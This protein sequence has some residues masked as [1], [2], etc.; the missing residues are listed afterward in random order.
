MPGGLLQL[1]AYGAQNQYLNGNPQMTFFKV[2]YRRYTNFSSEYIRQN[3]KGPNQLSQNVPIQLTCKIDRNGDLIQQIYFVFNIPD[4]YSAYDWDSAQSLISDNRNPNDSLYKFYW[5]RNL[6]T[7]I[8]NWVTISIGGQE[9]DK[10][11]GEWMNVWAELNIQESE[12]NGYNEMIGAVPEIFAPDV[13]PGSNG[14]YPVSSLNPNLDVDYQDP[15]FFG[16]K[17]SIRSNPYLRPPSINGRRILV[18]M[19]FWFCNNPGLSLPLIALQYHDVFLR[20]E[21]RPINELYTILET[22]PTSPLLGKRIRP[23]QL[24]R[25]QQIG[26]FITT[27]QDW[28]LK[29][30]LNSQSNNFEN[31]EANATWNLDPHFLINYYFLDKTE[32]ER[33]ASVSHEY[34]ITQMNT[35]AFLGVIGT[36]SL[37]LNLHH[38]SKQLI[39][40]TKRSD[41]INTNSWNNYT[42]WLT[43][44]NPLTNAFISLSAGANFDPAIIPNKS[45]KQ[46]F[47]KEILEKARILF[48]GE[49]RFATQDFNYFNNLQP[50]EYNIRSPKDG[51]YVFSFSI[52]KE[53]F[54]PSGACNMAKINK[55]QLEI[56]CVEVPTRISENETLQ[57]KY[58]FD[59]NMYSVNYNV[60]RIM[61]GMAGLVFTN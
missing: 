44:L 7:T 40:T 14:F 24:K 34:L 33:F 46:Y 3:V 58:G 31:S 36:K 39:W 18:P 60:L 17:Q 26:N 19:K 56:E 51:I 9:I 22:D 29:E 6:G 49:E 52:E 4:I 55:I 27:R 32:R 54:Q 15:S 41:I 23:N 47:K 53:K 8:I 50:Y 11:Y 16:E 13:S 43:D 5:I 61:A 28:N 42:N 45:N 57:Y 48:N 21:L 25:N 38:P 59:I 30:L 10:Q 1:N 12:L 35:S 20:I 37:D 2:V